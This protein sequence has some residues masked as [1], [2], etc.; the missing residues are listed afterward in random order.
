MRQWFKKKCSA[1]L[2]KKPT[3]DRDSKPGKNSV[4]AFGTSFSV[5]VFI[6]AGKIFFFNISSTGYQK[7]LET[8]GTCRES[9]GTLL[10]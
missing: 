3:N 5:R 1:L 4:A 9:T 10:I 6:E 7:S 8:P 2:R